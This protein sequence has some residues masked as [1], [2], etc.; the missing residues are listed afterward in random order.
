ME[1]FKGNQ[2][3]TKYNLHFRKGIMSTISD[4]NSQSS[5][6][7]DS[8]ASGR[9]RAT[10]KEVA[11]LAGVSQSTVSRVFNANWKGSVKQEARERVLKAAAELNYSPS[12]IAQ[13]MTS[14]R[15]GIIGVIISKSFDLFYYNV[16]GILTTMLNE[17][18]YQTM[19]FTTDPQ[20]KVGDLIT[21]MV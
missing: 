4:S 14:K 19:V 18:G 5:T 21:S 3:F 11:R 1:H 20:G 16:M 7:A 10:S 15:S 17:R 6:P 9:S 2:L 13:I 12:T 8:A